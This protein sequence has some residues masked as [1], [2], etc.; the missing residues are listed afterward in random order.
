M[1]DIKPIKELLLNGSF[2]SISRG[3]YNFEEFRN[4][5]NKYKVLRTRQNWH[6]VERAINQIN[7]QDK[8]KKLV[9][10]FLSELRN[11]NK[12]R[13]QNYLDYGKGLQIESNYPNNDDENQIFYRQK[14]LDY[15]KGL[16]IENN[17]PNNDEIIDMDNDLIIPEKSNF[18][19]SNQS[20]D[21]DK[22]Y[23]NESKYAD[24]EKYHDNQL[25]PRPKKNDIDYY[26][27]YQNNDA[28]DFN[29]N[30]LIDLRQRESYNQIFPEEDD[31]NYDNKE[32]N[33]LK[34]LES[35]KKIKDKKLTQKIKARHDIE[36]KKDL[37]N[38]IFPEDKNFYLDTDQKNRLI[39]HNY[40][41]M[42]HPKKDDKNS[43][44]NFN[45]VEDNYN[46][47]EKKE[48]SYF[49]ENP[50]INFNNMEDNYNN[51]EKKEISDFEK[52]PLKKTIK[53]GT[54]RR[55]NNK[56]QK[57]KKQKTKNKTKKQNKKTNRRK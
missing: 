41:T 3:V 26:D 31:F 37:Y 27:I 29:D 20:I 53:G 34:F 7:N 1:S 46:N 39:S 13:R 22:I 14:Y 15:G 8:K 18:N 9:S 52:N 54:K 32:N 24:D 48:I 5:F 16:K 38:Q 10:R 28:D 49:E 56:F 50:L 43:D 19:N 21:F 44:S 55:K 42:L 12:T 35:R 33:R 36:D 45:Y 47:P 2:P 40:D 30:K 25:R 6:R 51:P 11:Q 23:P 17:Y 4:L 57:T